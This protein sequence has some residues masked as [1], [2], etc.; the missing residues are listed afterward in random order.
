[1]RQRREAIVVPNYSLGQAVEAI[2]TPKLSLGQ[3]KQKKKG[4]KTLL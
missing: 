3:A 2:F 1:L 4:L